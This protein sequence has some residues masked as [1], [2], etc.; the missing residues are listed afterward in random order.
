[1]AVFLA[2]VADVR[3]GASKIRNPSSPSTTTRAKS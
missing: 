2:E 3:A 1:M